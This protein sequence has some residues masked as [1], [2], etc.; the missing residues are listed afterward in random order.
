MSRWPCSTRGCAP[1]ADLSA[2]HRDNPVVLAFL[3][4]RLFSAVLVLLAIA[5]IDYAMLGDRLGSVFFHLDFGIACSYPGCPPVEKLWARSDARVPVRV[6]AAAALRAQLRRL[7]R[8]AL[9][10]PG[11]LREP[12]RRCVEVLRGD[13]RA[14]PDRGGAVRRGRHAAGAGRGGR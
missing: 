1:P 5:L 2:S 14:V 8:A 3:V 13:A 10:P 7:P 4:R 11:R 6:R 12:G 9:L